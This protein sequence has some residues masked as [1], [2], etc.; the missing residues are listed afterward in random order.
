MVIDNHLEGNIRSFDVFNVAMGLRDAENNGLAVSNSRGCTKIR[1]WGFIKNADAFTLAPINVVENTWC[2][3]LER[4]D[5]PAA[6]AQLLQD[7]L[8]IDGINKDCVVSTLME[9][10]TEKMNAAALN[11]IY[12]HLETIS[13]AGASTPPQDSIAHNPLSYLKLHAW[14]L[15]TTAY[16]S[17]MSL[18]DIIECRWCDSLERGIP[19]ADLAELLQCSL[20]VYGINRGHLISTLL[21]QSAARVKYEA[22]ALVDKYLGGV[23]DPTDVS[24]VAVGLQDAEVSGLAAFNGLDYRKIEAWCLEKGRR[25]GASN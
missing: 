14:A 13:T 1:Q 8:E 22:L 3:A 25:A 16:S 11:V 21:Y 5:S 17:A 2:Y 12:E 15:G 19:T 4:G 24:N 10:S 6:L 20:A 7:S 23:I 9:V 18:I